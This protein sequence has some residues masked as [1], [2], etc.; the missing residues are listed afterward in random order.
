[1]WILPAFGYLLVLLITLY[2]VQHHI[3]ITKYPFYFAIPVTLA[4]FLPMLIVVLLPLD[5]V[6]HTSKSPPL[7]FHLPDSLI[8]VLWKITYWITFCLT[9]FILPLLQ[10]FYRLGKYST[11]SRVKDAIKRNLKY[12]AAVLAVVICSL[13][14]LVLEVGLS[15]LHL[16]L[17]AIA[18]SHVYSLV[19]AIWLMGHGMI[20]IPRNRWV[21]CLNI[22]NLNHYYLQLPKLMDAFEDT[23]VELRELALQVIALEEQHLLDPENLRFRDWMLNLS[24]KVPWGLRLSLER[25]SANGPAIDRSQ[26]SEEFMTKL[27]ADFNNNLGKYVAYESEISRLYEHIFDL[28]DIVQLLALEGV[29]YRNGP[30]FVQKMG[31]PARSYRSVALYLIP[32]YNL[33]LSLVIFAC[34]VIII[35]SEFLHSTKYLLI[36]VIKKVISAS[37][38]SILEL[39]FTAASFSYMLFAALN[40]LTRLKVFNMY[41]LVPH[42]LDPVLCCFYATY[43]ARLSLPLSYNF[44][45]LFVDRLLVFED[46]FGALIV[47][48]PLFT[49]INNWVPRFMLVPV[50]LASFNVY[51]RLKSRLGFGLELYDVLFDEEDQEVDDPNRR[52]DV[53]IAEA[54]RMAQR[55]WLK[56][57]QQQ[58]LPTVSEGNLRPFNLA[59]AA[60]INYESNRANFMDHLV[61]TVDD[62]DEP[63]I[64]AERLSL[65]FWNRI[66][67][68][69]NAARNN[70]WGTPYRDT[71][72]LG[73]FEIGSAS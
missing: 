72:E 47:L 59:S 30:K 9:W 36:N 27:T 50:L 64:Q 48:D 41:H 18:I 32:G 51:D 12:Q 14:Y 46:W 56:R 73:E 44:L 15:A 6:S 53:V 3:N 52:R 21:A 70:I 42:N 71:P 24:Q 28:E 31:L 26:I 17:M 49:V 35:E 62:H 38:H 34:L 11:G 25:L 57:L 1:M 66:N 43:I 16:K 60:D 37:H 69:F 10:E 65:P 63:E 45:T 54:K 23:K 19:I 68:A 7:W 5:Y 22:K 8:L 67:G 33:I 20:S 29:V 39:T 55:E 2:G 58:R 40:S 13:V 4:V 61:G